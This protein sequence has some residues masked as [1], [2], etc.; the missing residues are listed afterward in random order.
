MPFTPTHVLAVVPIAAV[1]RGALPFSALVIGSMIPDFPR[2]SPLSPAPDT[3][4]SATGLLSACLPLG[5]TC[6]LLFQSLM[7]RPLM[8]LMPRAIQGR[9][10]TLSGPYVGPTPK[11]L[12]LASLAI[13]VGAATH[14]L[15][16]SFTH[17]GRWGTR[18]FPRLNETAVTMWGHPIPGYQLLQD[19]STFIGLPCLGLLLAIWLYRRETEGPGGLP[20]LSAS[21]KIVAYLVA[22]AIP[23][24]VTLFVFWRRDDLPRYQRLGRS[25]RSSGLVL[26]LATLGY[27][28]AFRAIEGRMRRLSDGGVSRP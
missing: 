27:C 15:W 11:A 4:H 8:A 12:L 23:V 13:V 18:L 24:S 7:K 2:F 14:L 6:Y 10:A 16:D 21:W 25:A 22:V 26:M 20:V 17:R 1:S 19:G 5:L 9:C 28:L 3:T